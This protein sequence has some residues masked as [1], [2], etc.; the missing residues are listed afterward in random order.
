MMAAHSHARTFGAIAGLQISAEP[1]ALAGALAVWLLAALAGWYWLDL[2]PLQAVIGGLAAYV[3][4]LGSDLVHHIGHAWAARRTGYPMVGVCFWLI[5]GRSIYPA[6]EPALPGAVHIRRAL[7]GPAA[8]LLLA[9]PV[10]IASAAVWPW[11]GLGDSLLA[12]LLI[13]NLFL[14]LGALLPIGPFDG[15]TVLHWW[16][17]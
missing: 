14:G 7:G 5:F 9:V 16:G 17:R 6:D 8:N 15:S 3:L 1:S 12:F 11:Q 10:A 13:D 4:H 2:S